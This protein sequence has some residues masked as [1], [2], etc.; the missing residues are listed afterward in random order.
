MTPP[1]IYRPFE[2]APERAFSASLREPKL[3]E[4]LVF[5][6]TNTLLAPYR[7]SNEAL[8]AI[9]RTYQA[10]RDQ[11]RLVVPGEVAREF[12]RTR[13]LVLTRLHN[14]LRTQIDSVQLNKLEEVPILLEEPLFRDA[15][16]ALDAARED[17]K[18]YR[19]SL[20][21]LIE[22]IEGWRN[23]DPVLAVYEKLFDAQSVIDGE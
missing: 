9:R 19:A 12:A 2:T 3:D 13:P 4:A 14:S 18:R 20:R 17:V 15:A 6:D 8:Q 23:A 22:K 7:A 21:R 16:R 11:N 1:A 5:L 10:L